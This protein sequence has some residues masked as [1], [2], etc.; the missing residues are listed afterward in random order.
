MRRMNDSCSRPRY[1]ATVLVLAGGKSTRMKTNKAL[2]PL[3]GSLLIERAI[4]YC[5]ANF[6][7]ANP[8]IG[9]VFFQIVSFFLQPQFFFLCHITSISAPFSDV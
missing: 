1:S 6:E 9:L 5:L 7:Q 3:Q 8:Y 2:I 4:A